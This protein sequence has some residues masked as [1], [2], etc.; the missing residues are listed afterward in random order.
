[1]KTDERSRQWINRMAAQIVSLLPED[2]DDAARIL[3]EAGRIIAL[4][5]PTV[6]SVRPARPVADDD[7]VFPASRSRKESH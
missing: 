3:A 7:P 6:F 1:M 4:G 5:T 2:D